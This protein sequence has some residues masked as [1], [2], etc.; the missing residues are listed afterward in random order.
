MKAILGGLALGCALLLPNAALAEKQSGFTGATAPVTF[1]LAVHGSRAHATTYWVSYGPLAGRFG[2]IQL[3]RTAAH[4][5]G[6]TVR[7]P[8]G[9]RSTFY[10]LAGHGVVHTRAGLAP[11]GMVSTI[12]RVGP[13]PVVRGSVFR[14]VWQAPAG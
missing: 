12:R 6:A 1:S 11:G 7:L 2:V 9:A 14:A 4:T 3:H 10:Y 5:Y 8:A 13:M